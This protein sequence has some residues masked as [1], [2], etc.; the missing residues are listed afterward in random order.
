LFRRIEWEVI[1]EGINFTGFDEIEKLPTGAE[2]IAVWRDDNYKLTGK[3]FGNVN[4]SV[5]YMDSAN[6]NNSGAILN[7]FPICGRNRYENIRYEIASSLVGT[8]KA[9]DQGIPD[10]IQF[11]SELWTDRV[12]K[13]TELDVKP[14]C[15]KEWYLNGS[16][17][18]FLYKR[19]TKRKV[20]EE[21][22]RERDENEEKYTGLDTGETI[23]DY[24]LIPLKDFEV[25]IQSVPKS[26]GPNWSNN[27]SV[28]YRYKQGRIPKDDDRR[29]ISEIVSFLMGK[30]LL[31]VG[32]T[33]LGE[34][35]RPIEEFACNPWG[36]NVVY[37]CKKQAMCPVNIDNS[38][39]IG[40]LETILEALIP[41]YLILRKQL[42]LAQ[43]LQY[44]WAATGSPIGA[45]LPILHA[46]IEAISKSWFATKE[47]KTKGVYIPKKRYDNLL[48]DDLSSIA[49]KL[50]SVP[51]GD[52]MLNKIKS[53]YSFGVNEKMNFFFDEIGLKLGDIENAALKARNPMAHGNIEGDKPVNEKVMETRA[54]ETLFHRIL[55]KIL[56]YD[57]KYIDYSS[58]GWPEL[59]IDEPMRGTIKSQ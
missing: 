12:K 55:L 38:K 40:V 34:G 42:N 10:Y 25:I 58:I 3:V 49:K 57:G 46:G 32:Y 22:S 9:V 4:K 39:Q 59:H 53:A 31:Y 33:I 27:I 23:R 36:S 6:S 44:Y 11:E 14:V 47:S 20:H 51:Y 16:S 43:A 29:G 7:T 17:Y 8:S 13:I 2:K 19:F 52:K 26:V 5:F 54:Y 35:G 18:P 45:N 37:E 56:H 21:Y 48:K 30:Q 41:Q 50:Q 1:G 15:L 24:V 28:E